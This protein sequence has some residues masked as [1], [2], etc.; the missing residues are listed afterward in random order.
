MVWVKERKEKERNQERKW[1]IQG[2]KGRGRM[3]EGEKKKRK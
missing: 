1:I 3:I 2:R